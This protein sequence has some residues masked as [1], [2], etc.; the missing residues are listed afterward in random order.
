MPR[1][2][3]PLPQWI[4]QACELMVRY[5]L[6]LR[7][8]AAELG[9]DITV[10][11]AEALKDRKLFKEEL[12]AARI[13][14]YEKLGASL[15]LSKDTI[16]GAMFK[17]AARLEREGDAYRSADVLLKL[18]KVK[19]LVGFEPDQFSKWASTLTQDDIDRL[20]VEIKAKQQEQEQALAQS[21][22]GSR[23]NSA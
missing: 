18:A 7:Q 20:R 15:S 23:T 22:D 14:Y 4:P 16:T 2:V 12:E 6:S 13:Q 8:A 19:G 3:I 5:D 21:P 11:E 9:K 10:E 1:S 17:L